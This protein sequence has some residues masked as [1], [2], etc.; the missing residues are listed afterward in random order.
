MNGDSSYTFT[1][2]IPTNS[3]STLHYI[4]HA[5]DVVGNWNE[6]L[7]KNVTITD[8]DGPNFGL[9]STSTTGTTGEQFTFNIEVSDNI[10]IQIVC[11]EYWFGSGS[12]QN[13]TMSGNG[14]YSLTRIIPE[15]SISTLHYIFHSNDNAGNWNKTI[16]KLSLIHI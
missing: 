6:S 3:T 1:I 13:T 12:H 2:L 15:H 4:F 11:I 9:D 8:N 7:Q 5:E 16:Q 10:G 14:V